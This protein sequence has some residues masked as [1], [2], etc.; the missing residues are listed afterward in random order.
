[1]RSVRLSFLLVLLV[2]LSTVPSQAQEGP[3][4]HTRALP[5]GTSS[6]PASIDIMAWLEGHWVGEAL[7]G[8]SEEYWSAP[9]AGVMLGMYRM[10]RDGA[11]SF[12]EILTIGE[13]DGT[14]VLR[15]K[16]FAPDLTGWEAKDE[17]VDFR[18][19]GVED[20]RVYF[21][22]MT[23]EP[24]GDD[25]MTI[26]LAMHDA[27]GAVREGVFAYR[28]AAGEGAGERAGLER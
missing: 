18:F 25:A 16:H 19:V 10:V 4:A 14:L 12:Y 28:R 27:D 1:M 23:F 26:Y 8:V 11:P 6:P 7:G 17:T 5:P 2:T 20:G 21:D 9:R 3:T 15:L 24:Q 22:G 13:E